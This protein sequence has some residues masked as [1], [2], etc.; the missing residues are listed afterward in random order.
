MGGVVMGQ[1]AA[2]TTLSEAGRAQSHSSASRHLSTS[3]FVHPFSNQLLIIY[4]VPRP[5]PGAGDTAG[6]KHCSHGIY[7]LNIKQMRMQMRF[8]CWSS[9]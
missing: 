3:P 1:G 8:P 6:N 2:A 4:H 7:S 5:G 9:G